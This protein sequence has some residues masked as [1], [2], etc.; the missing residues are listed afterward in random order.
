MLIFLKK[1][2]KFDYRTAIRLDQDPN[3][4]FDKTIVRDELLAL[5][6]DK[7]S[8]PDGTQPRVFKEYDDYFTYYLTLIFRRSYGEGFATDYFKL[9]N[10]SL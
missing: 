1:Y 10:I 9:T 4:L 2:N 7:A 3:E 5:V 6:A 8:G